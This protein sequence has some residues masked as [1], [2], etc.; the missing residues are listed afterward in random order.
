MKRRIWLV[1][2][3][4]VAYVS[5]IQLGGNLFRS[6]LDP[7]SSGPMADGRS[8]TIGILA[9]GIP[10]AQAQT[11]AGSAPSSPPASPPAAY[12]VDALPG[13]ATSLPP[14]PTPVPVPTSITVSPRPSPSPGASPGASPSP[15]AIP[16]TAPIGPGGVLPAVPTFPSP[17][18]AAPPL[19]IKGEYKDPDGR[20]RIGILENYTQSTLAGSVLIEARDG[21]LAYTPIGV[22]S[23]L[24]TNNPLVTEDLLGQLAKTTFGRGENFQATGQQ[25]IPGGLKVDWTGNLTIAG[26]TQPMTGVILAK[27]TNSGVLLLLIAATESGTPNLPGAVTALLDSFQSLT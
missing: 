6:G 10:A 20:F 12:P 24:G 7:Q 14:S 21:S 5:C 17:V 2:L 8:Q 3:A 16:T 26:K 1:G 25:S 11:P 23:A 19:P 22:P 27:Q 4:V 13:S 9:A 18:L 15:G